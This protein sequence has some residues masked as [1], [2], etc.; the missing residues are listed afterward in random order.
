MD[1]ITRAMTDNFIDQDGESK[2]LRHIVASP[3][4][5]D[6]CSLCSS[7]N[8]MYTEMP[9]F[10]DSDDGSLV[11]RI[12]CVCQQSQQG[13]RDF[14]RTEFLSF[15]EVVDAWNKLQLEEVTEDSEVSF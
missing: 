15:E 7:S 10:G 8:N 13:Y 5:C 14:N 9:M 4:S 6:L 2:Q 1:Y 3:L 11:M 12:G